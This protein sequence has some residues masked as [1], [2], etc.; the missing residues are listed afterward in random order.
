M[1][2]CSLFAAAALLFCGC[3]SVSESPE[4]TEPEPELGVFAT[5]ERAAAEQ[6]GNAFFAAMQSGDFAAGSA[7]LYEEFRSYPDAEEIFAKQCQSFAACGELLKLEL[8]TDVDFSPRLILVYKCSFL[9]GAEGDD[10][11]R[12]EYD[13][14]FA[15]TFLVVD[16]E[17]T[18]VEFFPVP[19]S[20]SSLRR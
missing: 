19:L 4:S 12:L 14:L 6:K 18:L 7:I 3:R 9:S 1:K 17:V 16:G 5:T 20:L 10:A 11:E 8:A 15:L 2:Y 13:R